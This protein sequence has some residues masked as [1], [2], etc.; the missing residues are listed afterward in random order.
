MHVV[1]T[2]AKGVTGIE[3]IAF[4]FGSPDDYLAFL[5]LR[6]VAALPYDGSDLLGALNWLG[7][8]GASSAATRIGGVD[9]HVYGSRSS[10]TL[11]L[12][13]PSRSK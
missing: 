2:A 13:A 4:Q 3:A 7:Q 11:E 12:S 8:N 9:F 1:S 5:L 6:P 10:R